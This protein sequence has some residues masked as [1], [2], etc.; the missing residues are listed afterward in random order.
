MPDTA[1]TDP[2]SAFERRPLPKRLCNLERLPSQIEFFFTDDFARDEEAVTEHL[3]GEA[4]RALLTALADALAE[5]MDEG[6]TRRRLGEAARQL[7]SGFS[8]EATAARY[9]A[10]YRESVALAQSAHPLSRKVS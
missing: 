9:E 8:W 3:G 1:Q 5:L 2:G 7:A 10:L 6:E 4:A